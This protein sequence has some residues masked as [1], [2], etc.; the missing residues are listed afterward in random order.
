MNKF[1]GRAGIQ[2]RV[3]PFYRV[4][5]F[6]TLAKRCERGWKFLQVTRD[7][8]KGLKARSV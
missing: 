1:S 6:E 3:L 4:D 5:F 7:M 8:M 2:Q